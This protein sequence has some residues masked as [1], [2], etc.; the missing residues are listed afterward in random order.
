MK[1]CIYKIT[2]KV[3]GK[4]YIGSTKNV[5]ARWVKHKALLR[6][7]R[8]S[9][10]HLQ[11]AWNKYGEGSFTFEII[12]DCLPEMLLSRE[13]F[14]IDT[15]KPDYNQTATAGKVEM[16]ETMKSKLSLAIKKAYR[17]G[18]MT[19]TTKRVYQYDLRGN[20]LREFSSL[21]E[22]S[23]ITKTDLSHL[24]Q[25][26]HGACNIAGGYVWRFYKKDKLNVWFNRM[27]RPLT[28]EPYHPKRK[29]KI[30]SRCQEY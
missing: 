13:Q 6:H 2:N 29:Y 22:A 23:E 17:E 12:E 4:T 7:N 26:L 18:R 16:T 1:S 30:K 27:G 8:H 19:R 25:A 21:K 11:A 3:N 15:I 24:S 14:F 10:L 20:Y 9:N 28:K 5:N